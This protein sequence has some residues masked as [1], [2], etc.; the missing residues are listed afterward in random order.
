[1]KF[2][3]LSKHT[4]SKYAALTPDEK[5]A[6]LQKAAA[7]KARFIY[8]LSNYHPPAGYDE[9]GDAIPNHPRHAPPTTPTRGR[10]PRK[11]KAPVPRDPNAPKRNASAFLLYQNCYREKFRELNPCITFGQL[12][13]YSSY[14]YKCLPV[15]EKQRW[16]AYAAQDKARFEAEMA[17]Y[18]PPYGYDKTGAMVEELQVKTYT[19]RGVKDPSHPKRARGSFVYFSTEMVSVT[20]TCIHIITQSFSLSNH[21]SLL[22]HL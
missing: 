2:G 11:R 6:W 10:K 17:A 4:A 1:M 21:S 22:F 16:E 13:K 19:R 15:E 3:G 12:S 14:M 9:K 20:C 7:D 8:E 18:H 5:D